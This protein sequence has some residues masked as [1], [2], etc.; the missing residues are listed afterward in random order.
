MVEIGI[1]EL[2]MTLVT[3]S[4]FYYFY[5]KFTKKASNNPNDFKRANSSSSNKSKSP[6]NSSLSSSSLSMSI[7]FGSQSG[8]AETF[9]GE[10]CEEA[11][12][13]GYNA[14][15]IDLEDYDREELINEKYAVFLIATFGE[16]KQQKNEAICEPVLCSSCVEYTNLI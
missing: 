13:Y 2:V 15:V 3:I 5:T 8:T 12:M 10:L 7:F 16:G 11:K 6:V 4:L 1:I 14:K 9:A